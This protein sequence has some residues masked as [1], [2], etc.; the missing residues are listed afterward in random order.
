MKLY[1]SVG[2]NPR[3][4]RM[5]MAERGIELETIDVDIMGGDNLTDEFKKMNPSAQ[6]PCLQLD[7]GEALAEITVICNYLDE[8]NGSSSLV[9]TTPEE[10]AQTA[11]WVR[12]FDGRILEPMSLGFRSA[13]GLA[14]F[15]NRCHVVPE[16]ADD[17][18]AV[19]QSNWAWINEAL[20]DKQYFCGDRFTLADIQLYCFADFGNMIG[21]GFPAEL[22][23]LA[24]W[25]ARVAERP[26]IAA[27]FHPSEL[28]QAQ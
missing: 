12:R 16:S 3:V 27:S 11:M 19:V 14:I 23:N 18:K 24:A 4:L 9:G 10:R 28:A 21:Q 7:S 2:P 25:F 1:S 6:S 15:E 5:F 26:S 8:I 13:E 20:G 22:S 17:L